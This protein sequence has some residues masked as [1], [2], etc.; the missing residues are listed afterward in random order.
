MMY[1]SLYSC[2]HE[3]LEYLWSTDEKYTDESKSSFKLSWSMILHRILNQFQCIER[4]SREKKYI[5]ALGL[6]SGKLGSMVV[7]LA[8]IWARTEEANVLSSRLALDTFS[9]SN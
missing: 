2:K 1:D 5:T 9:S 6:G 4:R 3:I 7:S 8:A